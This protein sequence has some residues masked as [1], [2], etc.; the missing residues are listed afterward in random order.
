M[1]TVK[2]DKNR[3]NISQLTNIENEG[4]ELT[5]GYIVK[6][7]KM[8]GENIDFGILNTEHRFNIIIQNPMKLLNLKRL[9]PELFEWFWRINV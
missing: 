9:Y 1:E 3:I 7:D 6:I 2:R 4:D 8:D 5:G